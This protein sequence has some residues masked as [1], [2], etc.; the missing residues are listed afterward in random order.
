M[1]YLTMYRGDDR[2]ITITATESLQDA[3]VV[4][5][6]RR[7]KSDTEAVIEKSTTDTNI[8]IGDDPF[9]TAVVTLDAADTVDLTPAA[10]FWDVEVTDVDGKVH[11]VATGRL[12]ILE[13]ITRPAEG[14]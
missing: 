6:A 14:S 5:T 4:F 3:D 12:A 2:D 10:L 1:T 7:R 9:T 8:V 11:T 13:D